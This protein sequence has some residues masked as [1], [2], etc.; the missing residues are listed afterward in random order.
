MTPQ[1]K[2]AL[3]KLEEEA[4]NYFDSDATEGESRG[5]LKENARMCRINSKLISALKLAMEGLEFYTWDAHVLRDIGER[6]ETTIAE[7]LAILEGKDV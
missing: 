7:V 3:E 4:D 6:A 5:I 2:A 1:L